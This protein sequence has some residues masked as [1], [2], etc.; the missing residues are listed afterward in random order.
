MFRRLLLLSTLSTAIGCGA[1]DE[2]IQVTG[3]VKFADGSPAV[4]ETGTVVFH[5]IAEGKSANAAIGS[6][7]SFEAMT[8]KPGDGM[9]PGAYKVTLHVFK[10]Y[11]AQTL[12]IPEK[13]AEVSTTPLTATVDEDHKH[14]DFVVEP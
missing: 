9:R 6:D 7:G 4:G 14:F 2:A 1:G 13:Y 12:A 8:E 5:P 10:D 11:R 3:T